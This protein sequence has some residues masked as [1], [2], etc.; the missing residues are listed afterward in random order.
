MRKLQLRRGE[1]ANLPTLAEG[2]PGWCSDTGQLFVGTQTGNKEVGAAKADKTEVALK[3]DKVNGAT[4]GNFAGLN[5]A[6]NLTDSGKKAADFVGKLNTAKAGNLAALAADGGLAD[7]GATVAGIIAQAL[8]SGLKVETGTYTG[9]NETNYGGQSYGV[10]LTFNGK[11]LLVYVRSMGGA[12][13]VI[14]T[15]TSYAAANALFMRDTYNHIL[16]DVGEGSTY[17]MKPSEMEW[18]DN[19]V[20]WWME[21]SL[22]SGASP[23][24]SVRILNSSTYVYG[25]LAITE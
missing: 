7:S 20:S 3:A 25:Y 23:R 14:L 24:A 15:D 1:K 13:G 22:S 2:E 16:Y 17:R 9:A 6:G 5:A 4:A 18:G 8:A 12:T 19:S 10:T 11:P 21:N